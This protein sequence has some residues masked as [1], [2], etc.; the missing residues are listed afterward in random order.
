[1]GLMLCWEIAVSTNWGTNQSFEGGI[2]SGEEIV[3]QAI[4]LIASISNIERK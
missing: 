4:F 1:M 3:F 2:K